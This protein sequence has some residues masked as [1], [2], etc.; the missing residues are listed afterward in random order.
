MDAL[1][2]DAPEIGSSS[3]SSSDSGSARARGVE[4]R[5]GFYDAP[6]LSLRHRTRETW[7]V[8]LDREPEPEA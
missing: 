6:V 4:A 5:R 2:T 8:S 7:N 3:G 1:F